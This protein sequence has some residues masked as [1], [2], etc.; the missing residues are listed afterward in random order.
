M[1]KLNAIQNPKL[2]NVPER[3]LQHSGD[4][5]G[6]NDD[7]LSTHIVFFKIRLLSGLK[8]SFSDMQLNIVLFAILMV[9]L[10]PVNTSP[11]WLWRLASSTDFAGLQTSSSLR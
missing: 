1:V 4:R 6:V 9:S 7:E 8:V 2:V 11:K 3:F 5:S 10:A